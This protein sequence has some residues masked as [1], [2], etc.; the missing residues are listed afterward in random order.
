MV[1]DLNDYDV[2]ADEIFNPKK[3]NPTT[4]SQNVP[5]T[6]PKGLD[7]GLEE[8][9]VVK[10]RAPIAK[11]DEERYSSGTSHKFCFSNRV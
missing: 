2:S 3:G 4:S 8:V 5:P 11:L 7:L 10:K 9:Q 6:K 1:D